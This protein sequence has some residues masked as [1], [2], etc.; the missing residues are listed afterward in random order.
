MDVALF[1][2]QLITALVLAATLGVIVF[3]TIKTAAM[4]EATHDLARS[5]QD[6]LLVSREQVY[7]QHR[8][9]LVPDGTPVFQDDNPNWLKWEA[10]EQLLSLRN[11][12]IGPALN[13]ASVL[14]GCES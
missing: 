9:L 12:G 3:Y 8:P 13:I 7:D 1:V 11:I 14:Y 4:A 10:P 6:Q 5:S 2:L